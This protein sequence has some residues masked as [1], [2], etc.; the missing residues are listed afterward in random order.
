[1]R[2]NQKP[3]FNPPVTASCTI[4]FDVAKRLDA[5]RFHKKPKLAMNRS[6][7]L[8]AAILAGLPLLESDGWDF[9]TM[10]KKRKVDNTVQG[11][12]PK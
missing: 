2:S 12:W 1:M 4:P 6:Q 7:V 5:L 10:A 8:R 11:N 3:S 9:R